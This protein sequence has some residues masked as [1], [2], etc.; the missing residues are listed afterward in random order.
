MRR[1]AFSVWPKSEKNP[2]K[3]SIQ[4]HREYT[5]QTLQSF[6]NI[7]VQDKFEPFDEC[8]ELLW[9]KYKETVKFYT[10]WS[11][12]IR[13]TTLIDLLDKYDE[14]LYFDYDLVL[15]EEPSDYGCFLQLHLETET[16]H[17]DIYNLRKFWFRGTNGAYYLQKK[18]LPFLK[19][20]YNDI[21]DMIRKTKGNVKYTYPMNYMNHIE[22]NIGYI[23]G[24]YLFGSLEE[25]SFCTLQKTKELVAFTGKY[26]GNR[27]QKISGINLMGSRKDDFYKTFEAFESLRKECETYENEDIEKLKESIRNTPVPIRVNYHSNQMRKKLMSFLEKSDDSSILN[28]V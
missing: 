13:I 7:F 22:E 28:F 17:D 8:S 21:C 16:N 27:Y 4:H 20:H 26:F 9:N 24:Y 3:E 2:I 15:F 6:D 5:L 1:V 23:P 19:N 12:Y 25:P 10:N 11:D 14:A 18:H